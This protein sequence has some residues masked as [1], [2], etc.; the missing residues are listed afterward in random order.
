MPTVPELKKL[1]KDRNIK[2][3][4]KLNKAQLLT[5]LG[6]SPSSPTKGRRSSSK[7]VRRSASKKVRRSSSK[8]VR[9]SSSKKVRT[10]TRKS[11]TEKVYTVI[12]AIKYTRDTDSTEADP[13]ASELEHYVAKSSIIPLNPTY[14]DGLNTK[15]AKY[16]GKLKFQFTCE[17]T[18]SPKQI[19]SELLDQSLADGEWEATPGNGSFVYP[20][21]GGEQLGLLSFVY[22]MVDGKKFKGRGI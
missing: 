14:I 6:R 19:A 15:P 2:G 20:A 7:K 8:K 3:Y 21:K 9:R 12:F 22:V 18:L 11:S 16:I 13:T 4:S 10:S 1:C 5:I 17:T